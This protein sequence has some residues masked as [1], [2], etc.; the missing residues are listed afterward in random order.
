MN[1]KGQAA[2]EFLMTYGW[3]ILVVLAAIAALAYFGVLSPANLAPER[4]TFAAPLPSVDTAAVLEDG[5][6]IEVAF[7]NNVGHTINITTNR[8]GDCEATNDEMKTVQNGEPFLVQWD[9]TGQLTEGERMDLELGFEYYNQ[10]T[11]QT[12]IHRGTV[13]GKVPKQ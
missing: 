12:R 7:I 13:T 1:K 4:T 11:T 2:M 10:G 9:C 8:I 5:V 3:A 6:T